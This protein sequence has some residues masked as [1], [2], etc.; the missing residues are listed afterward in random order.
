MT[1]VQAAVSYLNG[2]VAE[3][4]AEAERAMEEFGADADIVHDLYNRLDE[5]EPS[6]FEARVAILLK[7]LGFGP[8]MFAKKTKDMSGGCERLLL[9]VFVPLSGFR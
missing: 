4:E 6:T 8:D 1:A 5:L 3:L 2:K 7:G 9:S